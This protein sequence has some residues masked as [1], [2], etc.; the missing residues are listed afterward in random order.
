MA[1]IPCITVD[2]KT[3]W[4]RHYINKLRFCIEIGILLNPKRDRYERKVFPIF[5]LFATI[6]GIYGLMQSFWGIL[7]WTIW[8]HIMFASIFRMLY[9]TNYIDDDSYA[10]DFDHFDLKENLDRMNEEF[11]DGRNR[12]S[13]INSQVSHSKPLKECSK[14]NSSNCWLDET[15]SNQT[16]FL[17]Q[18]KRV[19]MHRR[20]YKASWV[21]K[22]LTLIL[23][24]LWNYRGVIRK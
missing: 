18:F 6:G 19:L 1:E 21:H 2:F 10:A 8:T 12:I 13:T 7:I 16:Q 20:R 11:K 23:T 4:K 14:N 17:N 15:N 22:V 24:C 9:F 3:G 5:D